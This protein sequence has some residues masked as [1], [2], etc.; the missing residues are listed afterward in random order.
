MTAVADASRAIDVP[1]PDSID[2]AEP[3]A[4]LHHVTVAP[5]RWRQ[6]IGRRLVLTAVEWAR[7]T[8][9]KAVTLNTTPQQEAAVALYEATGFTDVGRSWAGP[10]ELVWFRMDL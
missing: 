5:E 7:Q 4:R 8:G 6:G 2:A 1:V 3:T 9:Y 10:Y